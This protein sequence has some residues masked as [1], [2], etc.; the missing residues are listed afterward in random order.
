MLGYKAGKTVV[1]NKRVIITLE[2]PA[3]A[4]TNLNRYSA[5]AKATASYRTNTAKVI[6]IEDDEHSYE[7]A[8]S[9]HFYKKLTYRRG[10]TIEEPDYVDDMELVHVQ[11]IHFCLD[12]KV[13]ASFQTD[14]DELWYSNGVKR[15]Q[16]LRDEKGRKHGICREW[17]ENGHI[18]SELNYTH[19][20]IGDYIYWQENELKQSERYT[21]GQGDQ[22]TIF[23]YENGDIASK[24]VVSPT[25]PFVFPR[26]VGEDFIE[27]SNIENLKE[28]DKS[29]VFTKWDEYRQ[30]RLEQRLLTRSDGSRISH[31]LFQSWHSNGKQYQKAIYKNGERDGLY[32]QWFPNGKK[33]YVRL[34]NEGKL[35]SSKEW[36]EDGKLID[37]Y[38]AS[39]CSV[40]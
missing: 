24:V 23:Y 15:R 30:F 7:E 28:G 40:M 37:S 12:R 36:N 21:C 17:H 10:D 8:E 25:T 16:Y 27:G 14:G 9:G 4:K 22:I 32:I 1:D 38:K 13:A 18:A 33:Q 11:G 34:Y 31:G 35:K 39:S 5:L 2:F 19:G 6:S 20:E 26:Y 3:D 29:C